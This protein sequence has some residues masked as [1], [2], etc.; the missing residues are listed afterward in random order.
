MEKKPSIRNLKL[1]PKERSYESIMCEPPD[2]PYG[3]ELCLDDE[4]LEKL[5]V[6]E[7]PEVGEVVTIMG[8]ARVVSVAES[9]LGDDEDD[10]TNKCMRLQITDLSV[11]E[12]GPEEDDEEPHDKL[13][14]KE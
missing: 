2:Y 1:E 10:G 12:G 4:T 9:A 8:Y 11:S 3:L 14:D 13:Y 7:L 5:G 6:G